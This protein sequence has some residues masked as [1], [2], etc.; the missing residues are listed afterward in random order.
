MKRSPGRP[1]DAS[2]LAFNSLKAAAAHIGGECTV[3]LLKAAKKAGCPAFRNGRIYVAEL[4][5]WLEK[6]KVDPGA[7]Q[8]K[9]EWQI[10]KLQEETR[11]LRRVND[12]DDGKLVS[13]EEVR[14]IN[15]RIDADIIRALLESFG[16]ALLLKMEGASFAQRKVL[17]TE[18]I[19]R[20]LD[21]VHKPNGEDAR[22]GKGQA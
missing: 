10:Q 21:K 14:E 3:E 5:A 20:V 17:I 1:R 2:K 11:R 16:D 12:V 7:V 19:D 22:T 13:I 9:E 18:A 8:G 6:N 15:A 4:S